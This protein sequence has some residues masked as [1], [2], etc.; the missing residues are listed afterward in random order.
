MLIAA[1]A[2]NQ[3]FIDDKNIYSFNFQNLKTVTLTVPDQSNANIMFHNANFLST[4]QY[5]KQIKNIL[6]I[7]SLDD[8]DNNID[9]GINEEKYLKTLPSRHFSS[10]NK[11]FEYK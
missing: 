7:L 2:L 8:Y 11:Y 5:S 3:N 6:S 10:N 9:C 4:A 1:C